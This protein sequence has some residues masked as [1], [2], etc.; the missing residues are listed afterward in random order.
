MTIYAVV[1]IALVVLLLL[2]GVPLWLVV[3]SFILVNLVVIIEDYFTG[4]TLIK[5]IIKEIKREPIVIHDVIIEEESEWTKKES[6]NLNQNCQP[7]TPS[8]G[9]EIP[10]YEIQN[11]TKRWKS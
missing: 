1:T 8:T 7:G 6:K 3:A 5:N 10:Q 2:A 9:R 4:G 11:T